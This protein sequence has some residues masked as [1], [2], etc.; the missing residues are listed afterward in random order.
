MLKQITPYVEK[1]PG[2]ATDATISSSNAGTAIAVQKSGTAI[3]QAFGATSS[4]FSGATNLGAV[5]SGVCNF[6]EETIIGGTTYMLTSSGTGWYHPQDATVTSVTGTLTSGSAVVPS[7]ASTTGLYLGQ[8]ISGTGI[9]AS[10]RIL[11]VDSATQITMNANA[12]ANGAQTITVTRLAKIIDANFPTA[13]KRIIAMDGFIFVVN[14]AGVIQHSELNSVT[15]WPASY[16]IN[17]N[18]DPDN[19]VG[20]VRLKNKIFCFSKVSLESFFNAGNP[21]GSVL[22]R[23]EQ[24]YERIGAVDERGIVVAGEFIYFVGQDDDGKRGVYRLSEDGQPKK[25]SDA[26]VDHYL[27]TGGTTAFLSSMFVEGRHLIHLAATGASFVYDEQADL[28][29]LWKFPNALTLQYA[30]YDPNTPTSYIAG[31]DGVRYKLPWA[32]DLAYSDGATAV[33]MTI[34]MNRMDFGSG[35][36]KFVD[37]YELECDRQASGTATLDVFDDDFTTAKTLGTFDMT[38]DHPRIYRGGA[39]RARAHRITHSAATPFRAS[40]LNMNYTMG[41]S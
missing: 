23:D 32:S 24:R 31:N 21:S 12:T 13:L 41:V 27:G 36:F 28:W 29:G 35:N 18:M 30:A 8:A 3:Y 2:F 26:S 10:T 17:S 33:T 19:A 34:L 11:T 4:I 14:S 39:F 6:F 16:T 40:Y 9:P 1:R 37:Y 15:L 20:I 7:I 5:D 38:K 22:G 25:I